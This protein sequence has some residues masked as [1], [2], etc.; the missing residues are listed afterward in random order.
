MLVLK[1]DTWTSLT[2]QTCDEPWGSNGLAVGRT[3]SEALTNSCWSLTIQTPLTTI[4]TQSPK[5]E[6]TTGTSFHT[7]LLSCMWGGRGVMSSSFS[8]FSGSCQVWVYPPLWFVYCAEV[9]DCSCRLL[10]NWVWYRWCEWTQLQSYCHAKFQKSI[11]KCSENLNY[12]SRSSLI[13]QYLH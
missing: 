9:D 8:V 7:S 4:F 13:C 1:W 2:S 10:S 12:K 3:S 5:W 6:T 11:R